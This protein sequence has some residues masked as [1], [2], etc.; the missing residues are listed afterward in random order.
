MSPER[1]RE[2]AQ[3][4]CNYADAHDIFRD[5]EVDEIV[6]DIE[7]VIEYECPEEVI[8]LF[9]YIDYDSHADV[10]EDVKSI[11][12]EINPLA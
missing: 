5:K 6:E 9:E 8:Y 10:Y 11:W 2:I 12:R 7:F 1:I 3:D 4:V